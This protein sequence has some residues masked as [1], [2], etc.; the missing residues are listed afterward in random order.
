MTKQLP[1]GLTRKE[2][3]KELMRLLPSPCVSELKKAVREYEQY[4]RKRT[5]DG[6]A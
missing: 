4:E 5:E 1:R 2:I 6:N 3:L